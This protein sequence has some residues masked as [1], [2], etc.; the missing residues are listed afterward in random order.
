MQGLFI[1]LLKKNSWLHQVLVAALGSSSLRCVGY[2]V[3]VR[4]SL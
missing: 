2:F 1:Y 3:A 4:A